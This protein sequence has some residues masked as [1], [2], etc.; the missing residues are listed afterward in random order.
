MKFRPKRPSPA[1]AV[2]IVAL[3]VASTGT[4]GAAALITGAD[5]ATRSIEG[6]DIA[7]D[8]ISRAKIKDGKINADKLSPDLRRAMGREA[9]EAI[10]DLGPGDQPP[11]PSI[12]VLRLSDLPAGAWAITAKTTMT[13]PPDTG[14]LEFLLE[15]V[16]TGTGHCRLDAAG[17]SDD[18]F[19]P[20]ATP[21]S[22][23]S[24]T[25]NMQLTRTLGKPGDVVLTCDANVPWRAA[26]SSIMATPVGGITL[27]KP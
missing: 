16:K 3:V 17:D 25:L 21:G 18:A 8:T 20:I 6:I 4:A 23:F 27:Q 19:Q 24:S 9:F 26:T 2:A 10:R 1:M 7:N 5:I 22:G 15:S 12:E 14:G 13:V 11:G